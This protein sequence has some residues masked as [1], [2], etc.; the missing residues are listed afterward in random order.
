MKIRTKQI[1][2]A[3]V[4]SLLFFLLCWGSIPMQAIGDLFDLIGE[5]SRVTDVVEHFG[6]SLQSVSL[7]G[8]NVSEEIRTNY[9]GIVDPA[10]IDAWASNPA[11]APGREVSSPWPASIEVSEL[12]KVGSDSYTITG[13]VIMLSSYELTHGGEATRIPVRLTVTRIGDRWLITQYEQRQP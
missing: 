12:T 5:P 11:T 4:S 13:D 8:P 3:V 10:L 7:H 6:R 1:L 9:S 2:V